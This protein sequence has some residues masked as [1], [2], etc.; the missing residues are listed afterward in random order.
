MI[1][2]GTLKNMKTFLKMSIIFV[3]VNAFVL[4][5]LGWGF[6]GPIIKE[7]PR[8]KKEETIRNQPLVFKNHE[9]RKDG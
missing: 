3:K 9:T 2:W 6:C 5:R 1:L 8:R 7:R 4:N